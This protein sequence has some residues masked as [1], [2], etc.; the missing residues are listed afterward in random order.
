MNRAQASRN[1]DAEGEQSHPG[2]HGLLPKHA[3]A[4]LNVEE[5]GT[6]PVAEERSAGTQPYSRNHRLL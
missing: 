2:Q 6:G 1:P 5:G 4:E 3:Q